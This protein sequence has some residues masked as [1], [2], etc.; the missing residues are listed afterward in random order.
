MKILFTVT[1]DLIF[2]QRMH[3][4]CSSLAKEGHSVKLIGRKRKHSVP[5]EQKSF[6]QKRV[7]CFFEKGKLFYLEYNLRLFFFLLFEKCDAICAIDTDTLLACTLAGKLK[8][9]KLA[10]DAHE[11]FTEVPELEGRNFSKNIWKKIE[12]FCIPKMDLW[13]TVSN[14]IAEIL[15][16]EYNKKFEVVYNVP[17]LQAE[18]IK[19]NYEEKF[20]LYQ[21]ALN[22]GRGLEALI[23]A[24]KNIPLK[25]KV[26]GE[27]DLSNELRA[28]TKKLN[29]ENKV[30][31]LGYIKPQE[32][33]ALTPK[34]FIGFNLLENIGL[35]YY[36]SLSNKF[37]D[38]MHAEI[39][40]IS[41]DFPEYK[42]INSDFEI[43][44]LT[45]LSVE[46]ISDAINKLL[47][48]SEYYQRLKQN[49][50]KAK[51]FYNW[52]SEEKKLIELY[53]TL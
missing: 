17:P 53:K 7:T 16:E 52:E 4:I 25:L 22:K 9:K 31:L 23:E 37:F 30:E 48:D 18:S 40:N 39:P 35:S 34:A 45:S 44:L 5:L 32:L 49:T 26:A 27:G 51:S 10:F 15:S 50:V 21:G 2:D 6:E 42:K 14:S 29:L 46:N 19:E 12:K 11:Y 20:I 28:L 47:N 13:Y 8:G 36:Y 38:Y 24:M 1:N 41:N 33:R 43:A 3:R